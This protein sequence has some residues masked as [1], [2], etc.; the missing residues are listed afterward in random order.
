MLNQLK[1]LFLL[2]MGGYIF[3]GKMRKMKSTIT[4]DIQSL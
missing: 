2:M 4:K 1:A 3:T